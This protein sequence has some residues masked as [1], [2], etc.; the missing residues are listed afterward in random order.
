[1]RELEDREVR[2]L[3]ETL[4]ARLPR[5]HPRLRVRQAVAGAIR[6]AGDRLLGDFYAMLRCRVDLDGLMPHP[7]RRHLHGLVWRWLGRVTRAEQPWFDAHSSD[8]L[9]RI[10]ELC[11]R[12]RV[13]LDT[14][15]VG[16]SQFGHGLTMQLADATL[17]RA[18]MLAAGHYIGSLTQLAQER[19]TTAAFR[20]SEGRP[21]PRNAG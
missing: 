18:D 2:R 6:E 16:I 7:A 14:V 19:L 5:W 8:L 11:G 15:S 4:P 9:R 10:G 3:R 13:P 21:F 20:W 17:K 12:H 1:M